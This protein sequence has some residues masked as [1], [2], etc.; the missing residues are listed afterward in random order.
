[1]QGLATIDFL[2]V[3]TTTRLERSSLVH[4]ATKII[5]MAKAYPLIQFLILNARP[6]QPEM[7]TQHISQGLCPCSFSGCMKS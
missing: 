5:I 6:K 3:V 7:P 2:A 1:M 4:T